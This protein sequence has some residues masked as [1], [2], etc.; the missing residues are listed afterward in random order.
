MSFPTAHHVQ[1][2]AEIGGSIGGSIYKDHEITTKQNDVLELLKKNPKISYR[3]ISEEL[4][5]N[6][7][8]VKKFRSI[9]VKRYIAKNWRHEGLLA[10]SIVS[11]YHKINT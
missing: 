1:T 4:G 9:K 10:N 2:K 7:S 11:Q 6:I 5:I 3:A 8:A